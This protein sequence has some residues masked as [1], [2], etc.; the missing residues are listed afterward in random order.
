[1]EDTKLTVGAAALE[2]QEK[3]KDE[4]YAP[5]EI[6]REAHKGESGITGLLE[7]VE[8]G[9]KEYPGDFYIVCIV[10]KERLL[11]NVIRTYYLH[12]YSCPT[13]GWDEAVYRYR[14]AD[15]SIEFLWVV[16]DKDTCQAFLAAPEH[17][18]VEHAQLYKYVVE[19]YDGTLLKRCKS[20]N[21]E[22]VD[23]P[24]LEKGS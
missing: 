19:Y 15:D 4:S 21:K 8:R 2:L 16:P 6:Q 3:T 5:V 23:S 20:Y 17:V 13:P 24:L 12:R 10:K 18:P 11:Q 22:Q 7:C 1:M 9:K 14:K